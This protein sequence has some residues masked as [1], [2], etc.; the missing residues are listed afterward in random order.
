VIDVGEDREEDRE[1]DQEVAVV[2]D[3]LQAFLHRRD[4]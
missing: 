2:K 1:G 3:L 4:E